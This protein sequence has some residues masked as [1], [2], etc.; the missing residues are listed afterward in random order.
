MT[1]VKFPGSRAINFVFYPPQ[2][3]KYIKRTCEIQIIYTII[4]EYTYCFDVIFR[5]PHPEIHDIIMILRCDFRKL[6]YYL[7]LRSLFWLT[8][9]NKEYKWKSEDYFFSFSFQMF[10]LKF[11][12]KC[13]PISPWSRNQGISIS[14]YSAWRSIGYVALIS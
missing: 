3:A 2:L 7:I 14:A 6:V 10:S 1:V 9:N 11:S 12:D 5:L 13:Y 4:H 8:T